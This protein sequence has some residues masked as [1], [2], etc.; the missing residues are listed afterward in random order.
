[1]LATIYLACGMVQWLIFGC[2]A[3]PGQPVTNT[4]I[5]TTREE[6]Q[7]ERQRIHA[8]QQTEQERIQAET[9][10][11]IIEA[12]AEAHSAK[13]LADSERF[14]QDS[15]TQRNYDTHLFLTEQARTEQRARTERQNALMMFFALVILVLG[16]VVI[17]VTRRGQGAYVPSG[18]VSLPPI[19]QHLPP[20][21]TNRFIDAAAQDGWQGWD[22]VE[23]E[24]RE[25]GIRYLDSGT[26]MYLLEGK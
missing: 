10:R 16:V 22:V 23:H 7:T 4:I 1:M 26:K 9:D 21:P 13:T 17:V 18:Y 20:I 12:T 3:E 8:E 24:G 5:Q 14:T 19:P 2:P 11:A 25:I 6:E 15:L